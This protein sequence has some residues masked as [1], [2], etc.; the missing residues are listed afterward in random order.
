MKKLKSKTA[1]IAI[2]LFLMLTV[3][4]TPATLPVVK[5]ED[6]TTYARLSVAPNPVGVNQQVYICI[7]VDPVEPT[8]NDFMHGFTV[9]I[10]EPDGTTLT[11]GPYTSQPHGSYG[12]AYTPTTIGNYTLQFSYPGETFNSTG[13]YYMPSESPATTLVVQSEPISSLQQAPLPSSYW[14]NPINS[15]NR[16]WNTISGDWLMVSYNSSYHG[17]SDT[18]CGYNPYTQAPLTS[19]IAWT[20]EL[21]LGGLAGGQYGSIGYYSGQS[22]SPY[23]TPPIIMDGRLYY[24]IYQSASGGQ[25]WP[26]V[27]CVDLRTGQKLWENDNASLDIAQEWNIEY[28]SGK[29]VI[30]F[31]WS[32]NAP[33]WNVY[34]P[35]TGNLMFSFTNALSATAY[36]EQATS[37]PIVFT[38]DGTMLVYLLDGLDGWF[39]MWNSTKCFLGNGLI[40]S[41]SPGVYQYAP[42]APGTYDWRQ[43][44]QW[45]ETIPQ[46]LI[47]TSVG[48]VYPQWVGGFSGNVLVA[49]V[50]N[51]NSGGQQ[52][53]MDVG[54]DLTTGQE[55]WTR[56]DTVQTDE[57]FYAF[58]DGIYACF[59]F[60]TMRWTAYDATTGKQLWVSDPNVYPW[61]AYIN[62]API[63]AN[64]VL[65]SGSFD[66]YVHAI[67]ITTGK[68]LWQFSSGNSGLETPTGTYPFWFGPIIGGDVVFAGTGQETPSQP[69]TLGQQVYAINETT[70]QKIWS[71]DGWMSLEA[72]A[73]GYL[74]GYNGYDS[75]IYC[76]GMGPSKTTVTA[77]DVGVTTATP[78][79]ITGTV[80]DISAGSQQEA[81]AA[82]FPNGLPCVSDASMSQF[83]EA[84]YMQQ[85]MPTNV[86]GVP[87]T[88]SVIDSNGNHYN[89]GTT[90]TN[91]MGE[92][93]LTWTPDIP[94]NFT[95]IATFAGT[96]GYYGSSASTYFYASPAATVVPTSAPV[97]LAST[98][99]YIMYGVIA[100]IVVI[101]IIGAILAMLMLRK[102]P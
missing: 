95:V 39:A 13:Q 87:V 28:P 38:A 78:I 53:F 9:H 82:N 81:V 48:V 40:Y 96:N 102:R 93:G 32:T 21:G 47:N 1:A 62:Y 86:T 90:T 83:M 71:I 42:G 84:V 52:A 50:G 68:E 33:T 29:G 80:T 73:D 67:N 14:T 89:I 92:Y 8:P 61:G 34:D 3:A 75:Q 88:L 2:A 43:G 97:S 4:I 60:L 26:G 99:T 37:Y 64:G 46:H 25:V 74:V 24:R 16:Q 76:F 36:S 17:F 23:L 51:I 12:F 91:A 22:Y 6:V 49:Q 70:G 44:I 10:K 69:L 98:Q 101:I 57:N 79:T 63:I 65:Y 35:S 45:N 72:I 30:P 19:H 85:P 41:T 55:L 11:F 59:S 77:P 15:A 20:S 27:V 31:L 58:G 7:F 94:G 66:G 100:I 18:V 54:Y 5:G 56:N